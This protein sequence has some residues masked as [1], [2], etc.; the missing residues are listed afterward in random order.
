MKNC[1]I[2]I[3][4]VAVSR[5]EVADHERLVEQDVLG[6]CADGKSMAGKRGTETDLTASAS[7]Q[8][9][10][11]W[12]ERV[13]EP[14]PDPAASS[15]SW[16][17]ALLKETSVVHLVPKGWGCYFGGRGGGGYDVPCRIREGINR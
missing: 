3:S 12:C 9:E 17:L 2:T 14:R 13:E 1:S 4:A 15:S 7:R 8:R 16:I 10:R 11:C 5:R 6:V